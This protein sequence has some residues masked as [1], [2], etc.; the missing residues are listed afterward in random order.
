MSFLHGSGKF[1]DLIQ[2]RRRSKPAAVA[3]SGSGVI[4][5]KFYHKPAKFAPVPMCVNECAQFYLFRS[6]RTS[7]NALPSIIV[8]ETSLYLQ[9]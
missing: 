2:F 7:S 9:H 5:I 6:R 4:L 3:A 8:A 1:C